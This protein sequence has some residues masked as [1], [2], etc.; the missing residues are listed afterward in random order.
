MTLANKITFLRIFFLTPLFIVFYVNDLRILS[1]VAFFIA[2]LTDFLDGFI[3]RHF[4]EKTYLGQILDPVA[5]K[6]LLLS[7]FILFFNRGLIPLWLF[8]VLIARD[9]VLIFGV[10]LLFLLKK[11]IEIKASYT[12]KLA[13]ALQMVWIT[14][15]LIS[16]RGVF[17]SYIRVLVAFLT[18]LSS[19]DYMIRG[20]KM[21]S[22]I[23]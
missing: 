5:D 11:E 10:V 16:G 8:S 23:D 22:K 21:L 7:A 20:Y 15:L 4:K 18:I 3:A 6:A 14:Y 12:G 1:I 19:L 9:V 17:E 2:A 13:V